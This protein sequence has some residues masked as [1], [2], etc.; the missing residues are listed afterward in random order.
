MDPVL[1]G[2]VG[3]KSL[4]CVVFG[5]GV[6]ELI[7][8]FSLSLKS[9]RHRKV[10]IFHAGL[11]PTPIC[12][13]VRGSHWALAHPPLRT[14]TDAGFLPSLFSRTV[15]REVI[16]QAGQRW[17]LLAAASTSESLPPLVHVVLMIDCVLI[18]MLML[19]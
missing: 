7:I 6:K 17:S 4:N 12:L 2:T 5:L 8:T 9:L 15:C 10:K 1:E 19:F 18:G 3:R 16:T 14:L 13:L 11:L